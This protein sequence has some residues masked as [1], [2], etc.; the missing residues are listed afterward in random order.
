MNRDEVSLLE[1]RHLLEDS[2]FY[3]RLE[4]VQKRKRLLVESPS[5][6]VF[7]LRHH[8]SHVF[9]EGHPKMADS[10]MCHII[11]E[12]DITY[13]DNPHEADLFLNRFANRCAFARSLAFRFVRLNGRLMLDT[14]MDASG[15][16]WQNGFA[17]VIN[18]SLMRYP[19]F[20]QFDVIA[21]ELGHMQ[22]RSMKI[23]Q[24]P[25][26]WKNLQK[27]QRH[28]NLRVKGHLRKL[29]IQN[30]KGKEMVMYHHAGWEKCNGTG[31]I[32]EALA[33]G[34]AEIIHRLD[35]RKN[36]RR[37]LQNKRMRRYRKQTKDLSTPIVSLLVKK[38]IPK[39]GFTFSSVEKGRMGLRPGKKHRLHPLYAKAIGQKDWKWV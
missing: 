21:H 11:R 1:E 26:R 28:L 8:L 34:H 37:L 23:S 22:C 5:W 36:S 10:L 18:L 30:K 17:Q 6:T 24:G 9:G 33:E 32:E 25:F 3:L 20:V 14:P 15:Q 2:D 29:G 7:D 19:L 38:L 16:Y 4:E 27:E 13:V 39:E 31:A 12:L 35:E